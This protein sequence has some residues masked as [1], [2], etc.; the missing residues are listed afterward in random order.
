MNKPDLTL[1]NLQWMKSNETKPDYYLKEN[2]WIHVFPKDIRVKR[3]TK[4]IFKNSVS[5]CRFHFIRDNRYS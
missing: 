4:I 1:D 5:S 3:S 2:S